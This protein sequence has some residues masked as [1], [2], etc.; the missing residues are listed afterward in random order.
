MFGK[1]E[2]LIRG[3]THS[4]RS[5]ADDPSRVRAAS[6]NPA[7]SDAPLENVRSW[8]IA[9]LRSNG[10]LVG[11]LNLLDESPNRFGDED[12]EVAQ[13]IASPLAI[14]F[15]QARLIE[16]IESHAQH[17]QRSVEERTH[18]LAVAK[19]QAEAAD[20]M[21]SAFLASMS[22][23]L[24]TPLN[25]IIGFTSLLVSGVVGTLNPEQEKQLSLVRKSGHHL[26]RLINDVLDI[27]RIEAGKVEVTRESFCLSASIR[28]VVDQTRPLAAEKNLDVSYEV[29]H[30]PADVTSDSRL[31][32]QIVTN[33]VSNAIKFTEKGSVHVSG[34]ISPGGFS[35]AVTDTGI[36][37]DEAYHDAI[38]DA[39]TQA[40]SGLDRRHEGTG[41]GLTISQGLADQLGG[42]IT[43]QS[44]PGQGSTFT[45]ALPNLALP[46]G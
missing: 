16:N 19:D 41:L 22:H 42:S 14:A 33:L 3:R 40:D 20:R 11:T 28:G 32:G 25:S 24:R 13:E 34:R 4:V 10:E 17:L 29:S 43:I 30:S 27:S 31:V 18:E 12:I 44:A 46:S 15:R 9:P 2:D 37:I 35:I 1:I 5:T 8:F 36:G 39:F 6:N 38:F 26:L 23:E 7:S 45:V 21:K